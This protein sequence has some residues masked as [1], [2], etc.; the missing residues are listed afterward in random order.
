MKD[1]YQNECPYDFKNI[2]FARYKIT[3]CANC[4]GL[5]GQYC[6]ARHHTSGD[7]VLSSYMT[8]DTSDYKY[9]YTFDLCQTDHSLNPI[10]KTFTRPNGTTFTPNQI[11]CTKCEICADENDSPKYYLNNFVCMLEASRDCM[12]KIKGWCQNVTFLGG[13]SNV[14][15]SNI[16]GSL[17]G[18]YPTSGFIDGYVANSS[19]ITLISDSLICS[20][21]SQ[22]AIYSSI[23][24]GIQNSLL[25]SKNKCINYATINYIYGST[26][27]C[28]SSSSMVVRQST[29][30]Y[31]ANCT[32]TCSTCAFY[33]ARIEGVSGCTGS[34]ATYYCYAAT[35]NM[36]TNITMYDTDINASFISETTFNYISNTTLTRL[37]FSKVNDIG[38]SSLR[39]V[40]GC[41]IVYSRYLTCAQD[42]QSCTFDANASYLNISSTDTT[43]T[44]TSTHFNNIRGTDADNIKSVVIPEDYSTEHTVELY[45]PGGSHVHEIA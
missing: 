32:I 19:T 29:I 24:D 10:G 23:I 7:T 9:F 43:Q 8:I 36:L 37:L 21:G 41:T 12:F 11:Q 33:L 44:I 6:G 39:N 40:R 5:V 2:Q 18:A 28:T 22:Y 13:C 15:I 16:Y 14:E 25:T 35:G 4:T 17:V 1:E 26:L 42:L 30:G 45:G 31:I 38:R 27:I 20:S 34:G 3:A